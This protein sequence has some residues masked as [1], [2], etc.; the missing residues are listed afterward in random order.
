MK[1]GVPITVSNLVAWT[2]AKSVTTGYQ[3]SSGAYIKT[4]STDSRTIQ[5]DDFFIPVT[6]EIYDGHDFIVESVMKGA[7]GFAV[8]EN[9]S[10]KIIQL[11]KSVSPEVWKRLIILVSKNNIDFI[12][13]LSAGYIR[14]FN[15]I[16]IGI[17]GSVGK[18]TTKDFI[19]GIL[20]GLFNIKYT[21]KNYNTEIGIAKSILEIDSSTQFFIS[22]LGMRAKGQLGVLAEAVNLD[23]GAITAVGPAHLK[24]FES[25]EEIAI[26]KAEIADF[27]EEKSGV[28]FLNNDD[29]WTDFITGRVGCRIKKFGR[30]NNIEFNFIEKKVDRLGRYSFSFFTGEKKVTE[31]TLPVCGYHNIYNA[32]C[33][34]AICTYLGVLPESLKNGLENAVIE[35][36]RMDVFERDGKIIISDCYN[37]SPLSMKRALD[38]LKQI[39]KKNKTRSIAVLADMLELGR[40]SDRLHYE[41]GKYVDDSGIDVL[42]AFGNMSQNICDGFSCRK[43]KDR[44]KSVKKEIYYFKNKKELEKKLKSI[45]KKGDTIL[46]KGSRANKLESLVECI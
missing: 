33:A 7:S 18:T 13:K 31:V 10:E 42:I 1:L 27:L 22:E 44:S 21:P 39:S 29:E 5:K 4:I 36:N 20:A 37:A 6:G 38:T 12:I 28:L 24:Y 32:C 19:V 3:K 17:T 40:Q 25:V 16:V 43:D 26:S 46:I 14:K 45:I 23:I 15:P 8:Q 35:S 41:L 11:Q 34:A 9:H 30:N 2:N